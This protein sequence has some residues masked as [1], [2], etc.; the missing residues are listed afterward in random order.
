MKSMSEA[1]QNVSW[2]HVNRNYKPL[3]MK[4]KL[5]LIQ[6]LDRCQGSPIIIC[7]I[8]ESVARR[9]GVKC[10]TLSLPEHFLL[11]WKESYTC[12]K[13]SLDSVPYFYIDVF[14]QGKFLNLRSCPRFST[15]SQCPMQ[16]KSK[17]AATTLEVVERLA[18][19]LEVACRQR[20]LNRNAR[21]RNALELI[22]LVNPRDI[23][24]LLK[25]ARLYMLSNMDIKHLMI[26]LTS[27]YNE[28]SLDDRNR[29]RPNMQVF[30]TY[31]DSR[32]NEDNNPPPTQKAGAYVNPAK[33]QAQLCRYRYREQNIYK[34]Q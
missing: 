7:I 5:M 26:C 1:I 29:L 16:K 27:L 31:T 15:G 25:L 3:T 14:N 30:Q 33:T 12:E 22:H 24:C 19:N 32:A 23:H 10:D 34:T 8:Y 20:T 13:S 6:V 11:R 4:M 9:L 28:L 17:P 2:E 21:L 18:N